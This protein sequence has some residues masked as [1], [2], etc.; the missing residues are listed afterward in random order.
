MFNPYTLK[1]IFL[2]GIGLFQ[3]YSC[4]NYFLRGL[5]ATLTN[6]LK[7]SSESYQLPSFQLKISP[8]H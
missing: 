2:T 6:L 8:Q 3:V 7:L 5:C 4:F 1:S